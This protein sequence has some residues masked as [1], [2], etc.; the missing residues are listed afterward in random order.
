VRI[1]LRSLPRRQ[2]RACQGASDRPP[3]V[4]LPIAIPC[5]ARTARWPRSGGWRWLPY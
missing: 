5:T 1:P 3:Q 4:P 2:G